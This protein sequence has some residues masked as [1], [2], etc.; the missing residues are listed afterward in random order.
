MASPV[1]SILI[2]NNKYLVTNQS[3]DL[4]VIISYLKERGIK[5]SYYGFLSANHD[6]IIN[7]ILSTDKCENLNTIW[8]H[9][10][11]TEAKSQLGWKIFVEVKNK[12]CHFLF[13]KVRVTP[14]KCVLT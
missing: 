7:S 13:C 5:S 14:G 8:F 2:Y 4:L 1:S 3:F 6:I 12:V 11:L 9:H 10:F